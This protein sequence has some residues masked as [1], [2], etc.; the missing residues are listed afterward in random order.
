MACRISVLPGKGLHQGGA[1]EYQDLGAGDDAAVHVT[2]ARNPIL[3]D[4][5]R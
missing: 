3:A 2:K 4:R 5:W 1:L